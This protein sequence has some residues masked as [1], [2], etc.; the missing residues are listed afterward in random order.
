M[1]VSM[2]RWLAALV[3]FALAAGAGLYVAAGR[4][5]PPALT[6]VSPERVVGQ[7]GQLEIT[8]GAP[9]GR[10]SSL[11]I[12]LEQDG[13]QTPLFALDDPGEAA[14]DQVDADTMR[15]SRPLGSQSVPALKSGP[16]RVIVRAIRSGLL[17][18]RTLSSEVSHDFVVR[19]EPPRLTVVSTF[20]YVNHG[21]AEFVLY[22]VTPPDVESGVRVGEREYKGFPASGAGIPGADPELHL[23]VFAL[24]H[25]QDL[26]TPMSI[27]ARDEAGNEASASFLDRV[28]PR[29]FRRSRISLD[30]RFLSRV[31][32]EIVQRSPELD[33]PTPAGDLLPAFL[34]VNGELRQANAEQIVRITEN[35][36]PTMLWDG[37]FVQLGNSQVEAG[38]ADHRTY[39]YNGE[40]VDQQV[41]LGFDLAVTAAVSIASANNG[42]VLY[43]DYLGIYGNCVIVDHG[44]GVASLYGHLSSIDVTVGATV[45]KGQ[46]LG[47]SG[48][49]GLAGGD[50]LHFTML[51]RGQPVNPVEWW[52]PIWTRDRL[53][54]KLVAA[55]APEPAPAR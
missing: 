40:D 22:R 18:L 6:I 49:T 12:T 2:L 33:V 10:L 23:A 29:P 27:F 45:S 17:E 5:T 30:D 47:R 37:P 51:V 7:S 38:F 8:A 13:Q 14:I 9:G 50:H 24:L 1:M 34:A 32:P 21:G 26:G 15:I 20:H 41:H 36:S 28:F 39:V 31:V 11:T 4:G 43:A 48:M 19:L 16:A 25:D 42:R 3:L 54:R 35:T 52:D 44:L 53:T 55:G 46:T